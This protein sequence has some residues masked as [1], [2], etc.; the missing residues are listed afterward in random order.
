MRL[1]ESTRHALECWYGT[2]DPE[3]IWIL[4]PHQSLPEVTAEP[5]DES[6]G[7][8]RT[9]GDHDCNSSVSLT[10]AVGCK[11]DHS[12]HQ[13]LAVWALAVGTLLNAR[14]AGNKMFGIC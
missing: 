3:E 1:A 4:V 12:Q 7:D 10:D 11:K 14:S 9:L 6:A 13:R 2:S 8:V 5:P